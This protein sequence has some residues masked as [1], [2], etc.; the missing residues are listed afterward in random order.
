[1][2]GMVRKKRRE[3]GRGGRQLWPGWSG[4][5]GGRMAGEACRVARMVSVSVQDG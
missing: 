3:D 1:M 4:R 5:G 2:A